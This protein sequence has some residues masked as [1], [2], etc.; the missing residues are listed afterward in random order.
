VERYPGD[1]FEAKQTYIP[2]PALAD[3]LLAATFN[4]PAPEALAV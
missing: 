2:N 1:S 3:P 4:P